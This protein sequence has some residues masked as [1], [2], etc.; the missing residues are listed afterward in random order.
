MKKSFTDFDNM[1][2]IANEK[3]EESVTS[4]ELYLTMDIQN[5]Q[6]AEEEDFERNYLSN[7][8]VKATEGTKMLH[9]TLH[10]IAKNRE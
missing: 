3:F 6:A 10:K 4:E 1:I 9:L 5:E 7:A 2:E 8:K